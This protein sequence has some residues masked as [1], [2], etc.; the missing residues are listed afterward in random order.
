MAKR[1]KIARR[2]RKPALGMKHTQEAK[3]AWARAKGNGC[4]LSI[5]NTQS[6]KILRSYSIS[7]LEE[8]SGISRRS[9]RRLRNNPLLICKG[10]KLYDN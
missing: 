3:I 4:E 10:W 5:I 8:L 1:F 7:E 6:G 2:G 9:L